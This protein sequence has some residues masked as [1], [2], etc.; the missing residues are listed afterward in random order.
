MSNG[1][2]NNDIKGHEDQR[3]NYKK[4]EKR[5]HAGCE[6]GTIFFSFLEKNIKKK[7]K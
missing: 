2:R 7:K 1:T 6:M 5:L 3:D 4:S